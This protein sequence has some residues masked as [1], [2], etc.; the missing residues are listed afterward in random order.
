MRGGRRWPRAELLLLALLG[1]AQSLAYARPAAWP[2]VAL[3]MAVLAWRVARAT[4]WQAAALGAAY[5]TAWVGGAVWWLFIS[6]H[7]Y[8]GL[9]AWMAAA[10]V[11]LLALALSS[12]LALAMAAVARGRDGRPW[13]DTL[14][15]ATAWLAAELARG[16]LLT[17]FPWAASGYAQVDGPLAWLAPWIGVYGLGAVGAAFAAGAVQALQRRTRGAVAAMVLATAAVGA[18]A[19]LG[20]AEFTQPSGTLKVSLLQ[21][22]VAQDEKFVPQHLPATLAW[23]ATSLRQAGGDL[24]VAPETAVPLLPDQLQDLAPGYWAALQSHFAAPGRP[25]AL[26]GVPLGDP[27]DGYTNSVVGMA[28]GA[29]GYRYDKGHL[30][31]F[32]EFIPPM[33]RWFTDMMDIPLGDFRRGD[34]DAPAFALGAERLLPNICYEDLFGEELATRFREAA[35]APTML[36]NISNIGWFGDSGAAEQH[37]HI[38]RMRTL[39][40]QRPMLRATNTG[41]TALIDHRGQVQARLPVFTRAVLTGTVQGRTGRTPYA[42]WAGAIGLWPLLAAAWLLLLWAAWRAGP[43]ARDPWG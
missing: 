10:A 7:R 18:G 22:N 35:H 21:P 38:S 36:V 9:P 24:V 33:F 43:P 6:M 26:I 13:H 39:E 37:L 8:G 2:L 42:A 28:A 25:A 29:A 5:G 30:V 31:P 27:A 11:A 15:F 16:L 3:G 1:A 4:P 41:T 14:L 19:L 12:V 20:P 17:G 32:G 40:L 34:P 23:V